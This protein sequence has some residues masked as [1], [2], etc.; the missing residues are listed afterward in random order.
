MVEFDR[1]TSSRLPKDN[2]DASGASGA[3]KVCL[4][5]LHPTN[6]MEDSSGA[7][8]LARNSAKS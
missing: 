5:F 3:A 8:S 7:C 2:R 6:R 4:R 1:L